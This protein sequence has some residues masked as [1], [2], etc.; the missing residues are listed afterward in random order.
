MWDNAVLVRNLANAL[1]AGSVL[2]LLCGA[3]YYMAH[4][5]ELA[6]LRSVH[7]SVAPQRVDAEAVLQVVR[8]EVRGNLFTVD[9][10]RLRQ[11]LERLPWVRSVNIRREFP[12][13]LAVQLEEHQVLARWNERALV[14][15]QGEVFVAESA[16]LLPSFI[17]PDGAAAE[18]A[19]Q[20]VQ[21]SRQLAELDLRVTQLALSP[22]HAWQLRLNNGVVLELGREELQQRV[23][24]FV[25][26]YPY[27]QVALQGASV[28][29]VDLRYR[30]GFAVR[31]RRG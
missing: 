24:R 28:K 7:L 13:R 4:L 31:V 30:N 17:G 11:S 21:F 19:Q 2:A 25:T 23:A 18:V 16:Q 10:E 1:I 3:V 5:P 22:R 20:Y 26:G 29:H 9:I 15:Q 12:Q 14:S 6:P 8:N 27:S